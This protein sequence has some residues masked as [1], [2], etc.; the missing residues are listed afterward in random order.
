MDT[1]TTEIAELQVQLTTKSSKLSELF[2]TNSGLADKLSRAKEQ[3]AAGG[4]V[5]D[6]LKAVAVSCELSS[7]RAEETHPCEDS[8]TTSCTAAYSAL[9]ADWE[10]YKNFCETSTIENQCISGL[11]AEAKELQEKLADQGKADTAAKTPL[12]DC[13]DRRR[14]EY[15]SRRVLLR[16]LRFVC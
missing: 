15:L 2:A 10:D 7:E 11:A 16:Y 14:G 5:S 12:S 3:D 4:T 6:D 9:L 8:S 13:G 1:H